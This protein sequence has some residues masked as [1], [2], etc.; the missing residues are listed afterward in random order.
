MG[1]LVLLPAAGLLFVIN[2]RVNPKGRG[3]DAVAVLTMLVAVIAGCGLA[4]TFLGQWFAA[5]I[6]WSGNTMSNVTG[7][8]GFATG[9]AI[10]V[11]IILVGVAVADIAF[12][13]VADNGAQMAAVL[14]PTVL[15]LVVG[16]SMGATGGD[17][18]TAVQAEMASFFSQL[19]GK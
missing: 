7:E 11:A 3:R 13:R 18:V 15:A 8:G 17:A 12:D 10:A 6:S 14:F 9:L 19:G 4:A 2:K 1:W 5:L 16:G